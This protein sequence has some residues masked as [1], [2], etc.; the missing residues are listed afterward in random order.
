MLRGWAFGIPP[1]YTP[2]IYDTI[3]VPDVLVTGHHANIARWR[4]KKRLEK[5]LAYRPELL[6]EAMLSDDLRRLIEELIAE[7]G[8]DERD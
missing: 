6:S 1:V 3:A 7:G 5:T 4:L 8:I 2:A